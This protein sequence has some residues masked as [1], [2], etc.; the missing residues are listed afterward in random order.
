M[1]PSGIDEWPYKWTHNRRT[2]TSNT[3]SAV[4]A[5]SVGV[6]LEWAAVCNCEWWKS[7]KKGSSQ[8]QL[9]KTFNLGTVHD[10]TGAP[11]KHTQTV[12]TRSKQEEV[13]NGQVL[14]WFCFKHFSSKLHPTRSHN[15]HL[16]PSNHLQWHQLPNVLWSNWIHNRVIVCTLY[17]GW[18]KSLQQRQTF[19]PLVLSF[20]WS[21]RLRGKNPN[22]GVRGR[23]IRCL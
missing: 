22:G 23:G 11:T 2:C 7:S 9:N 13:I 5:T 6:S 20:G 17:L 16:L 18:F 14:L 19:N 8:T 12:H 10:P 1:Q 4:I 3:C 21:S 15:Q